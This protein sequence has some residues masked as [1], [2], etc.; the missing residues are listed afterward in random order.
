MAGDWI[1]MRAALMQAPEL[2]SMA[3]VLQENRAFRDWLTPGG[4]SALNGQIVTDDALRC[5]T[6]AALLRVWS[7]AREHGK[8]DGDDLVL[9]FISIVD[10]DLLAGIPGVGAAME[11][12][13]WAIDEEWQIRL[14]NFL[15][16]NVPPQTNAERQAAFRERNPQGGKNVGK[17]VTDS[18]ALVVTS[19]L[20]EKSR[21]YIP[22]P[23]AR[24]RAK[25]LPDDLV[26]NETH[27]TIAAELS[28]DLAD[29]FKRFQEHA[30]AHGRLLVDWNAGFCQWLRNAPKF[31]RSASIGQRANLPATTAAGRSFQSLKEAYKPK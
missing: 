2:I 16:H 29:Q 15:K 20:P 12:V 25:V 7:A 3:R 24:A 9:P 4:G 21:V 6:C 17:S 30:T 27:Q 14:P 5:V 31:D 26:P 1:K 22:K 19:P 23:K 18:N 10:L 28:L 11:G 8:F 13:Q